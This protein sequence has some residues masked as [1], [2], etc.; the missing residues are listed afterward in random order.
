MK[1]SKQETT[2]KPDKITELMDKMQELTKKVT[3]LEE[4]NKK[5]ADKIVEQEKQLKKLG[6]G[7]CKFYG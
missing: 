1:P 2:E 5:Q 4:I 3:E 7:A 6:V